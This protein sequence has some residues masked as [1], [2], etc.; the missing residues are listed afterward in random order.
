MPSLYM[1]V[2]V[3]KPH[4]LMIAV[5]FFEQ[6]Y[7]NVTPIDANLEG[8]TWQVLI[9]VGLL[10]KIIRKVRVDASTGKILGHA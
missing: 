4:A 5:K 6:H 10:T 1:M 8:D 3:D 2:Q 9:S 7:D